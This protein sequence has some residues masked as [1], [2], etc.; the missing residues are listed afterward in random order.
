M[1]LITSVTINPITATKSGR[2]QIG[3]VIFIR[4]K[5][6][7]WRN[8]PYKNQLD[9][10][11]STTCDIESSASN[12][13]KKVLSDNR[14]IPMYTE[15]SQYINKTK[16]FLV[17]HKNIIL[18]TLFFLIVCMHCFCTYQQKNFLKYFLY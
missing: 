8:S 16:K 17:H 11:N 2:Y 9:L 15:L 5:V 10:Y 7:Y 12:R 4:L 1:G 3:R 18:F 14:T 13:D 6:L